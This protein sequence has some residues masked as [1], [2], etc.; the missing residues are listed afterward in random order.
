MR[1]FYFLLILIML[2][3]PTTT[4][5]WIP[6][7]VDPYNDP[8]IEPVLRPEVELKNVDS[9]RNPTAAPEI[10]SSDKDTFEFRQEHM[11]KILEK[12]Y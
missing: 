7:N 3:I 8:Q 6:E 11:K 4:L 2:Q 5:A 10:Q 1:T 12:N 9:E